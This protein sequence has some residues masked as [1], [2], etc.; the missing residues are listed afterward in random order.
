MAGNEARTDE[1]SVGQADICHE[2]V[3]FLRK[4][5]DMESQNRQNGMDDLRFSYGEQ[6]SSQMQNTRHLEARPW[7]TINV[8]EAFVRQV[9]NQ[10]RQQRPRMKAHGMN[11]AATA[12]MAEIVT[13]LCRHIEEQS[14]AANAYDVAFEFACRMGWGYI[15]LDGDYVADNSFD[16]D[17]YIRTVQNPFSVYGDPNSHALDGSDATRTLITDLV[18][19][20]EFARE[21][22]G[23]DLSPFS[24]KA[25]GD[26]LGEWNDKDHIRIA[27]FYRIDK[28]RSE[29]IL[30]SDGSTR[31][32]DEMKDVTEEMLRAHQLHVKGTRESWKKQV[33][34]HKVTALQELEKREIPGCYIPVVPVYFA[35]LFIDGRT[36]R[37]GIVRNA[38]DPQRMLNYWDTAIAE[39]VALAPKAKWLVA[40]GQVQGHER[41]WERANQVSYPYLTYVPVLGP[42]GQ[43]VPPPEKLPI[44]QPPEGAMAAAQN[45]HDNLQR[46][47]GMFDPSMTR[48]GQ[49]SGKAL[50]AEQQQNDMSNY[51]GYDNLTKSIRHIGRIIMQWLPSYYSEKRVQRIIGVD[52]KPDIITLNEK[53]ATGQVLNNISVGRY[54]ITMETGPGYNSK[55]QEAVEAMTP[56]FEG[57][58]NELMKVA[59]DIYFRYMDFPGADVI[60]DRLAAANPLAQ[61]DEMSDVPPAIQMQIKQLTQQVQQV[62]QEL[63]A[64]HQMLKSRADVEGMK[65]AAASHRET[66]KQDN[67]TKRRVMEND[68]WIHEISTKAQTA[69]NV[70]ELKGVVALLVK[71]IDTKHLHIQAALDDARAENDADREQK[72]IEAEAAAAPKPAVG[73]GQ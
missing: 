68:A 13:G 5:A 59:G 66:I 46:V 71:G 42:D 24:L 20:E 6:W 39:L 15:R 29:L 63:Q 3:R 16:Q 45:A 34:W 22:P 73:G 2:A 62:T 49:A 69:Q 11:T 23:A 19:R 21:Y 67:E 14:D 35:N 10:Q 55:R 36:R 53:S 32:A 54:D 61:I 25:V 48:P 12:K 30:L 57:P 51:H 17:I 26:S 44:E 31:W 56:L 52:G 37:F 47:L 43:P 64:A 9:C 4:S 60:A 41:E 7:F 50:N 38:K 1:Q 70:E 40:E 65:E 58:G 33:M 28:K 8:T 18:E 27:E 72:R